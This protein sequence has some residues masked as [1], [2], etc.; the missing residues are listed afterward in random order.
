MG[1]LHSV[2]PPPA[3]PVRRDWLRALHRLAG[4]VAAP[5]LLISILL[6]VGLT[7][8]QWLTSLSEQLYPSLPVPRVELGEPVQPGSWEQALK[9]AQ[10]AVGRVG[11]VIT[12]RDA[13]T[14]VVQAF[15][16]H[17]HD[18][19]VA[20]ANAHVQV[21]VD[22]R[23]MQ[24]VRVQDKSSSLVSRAHGVHAIRFFG[25]NGFS[26]ATVSSVA[27]LVLLATG[28]L[29]SW[30]DQRTGVAYARA[31]RWHLRLGRVLGVFIVVIALTTLDLEFGIFGENDR[32]ASHPVPVVKLDEPVRPGSV[33]QARR[34]AQAAT[35][36]VMRAVFIRDAG[37]DLK[38]SEAGDGIGGQ[39]VWMNAN[40]MTLHRITDWRNDKQAFMFILHDGRFLGGMNALNLY[41]VAALILLALVL[42]GVVIARQ[43]SRTP[44]AASTPKEP[45][46][47]NQGTPDE[48]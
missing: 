18:P 26:I 20:Q 42:N 44:L 46:P 36:G 16:A 29:L 27:L 24:V 38:F 43:R 14:V 19:K 25:I 15:E 3:T 1:H 37:N 40:T 48:L 31:S 4:L 17:S 9:V 28:A 12:T 5:F 7:H 41:D 39:S 45:F 8:A 47:K 33:D 22:T 30:R 35:G 2:A 23:T 10:L 13:N 11:H 6:A 34:L 21:L 32:T